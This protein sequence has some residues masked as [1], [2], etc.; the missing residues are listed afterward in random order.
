MGSDITMNSAHPTWQ[1][2]TA[3][4]GL[5]ALVG[6]AVLAW[7]E[8]SFRQT[9]DVIEFDVRVV[10]DKGEPILGLGA[11]K[12]NVTI[13]GSPRHVAS[14]ALAHYGIATPASA[15][16]ATAP[17][18]PIWSA[19]TPLS[20]A[21]SSG[22]IFVLVIDA[23]TFDG[24]SAGGVVQAARD[25]VGHLQLND[26]VGLFVFPTGSQISP[27]T[28]RGRVMN[29]LE[30]VTG[31][32]SVTPGVEFHLRPSE[33]VALAPL[34]NDRTDRDSLRLVDALCGND[35][36]C[37]TRLATEVRGLIGHYEVH[38]LQ[39]LSLLR[40]L[41]R[42]LAVI[43]GRKTLVL[44]SGGVV[45]SNR[46]GGRPDIGNLDLLIGEEAIRTNTS[47]YTLYVDWNYSQQ[48]T[49]ERRKAARLV[50]SIQEDSVVL[51]R[52][53]EMFTGA[54]GGALFKALSGHGE[55]AFNRILSET[56]AYYVLGVEPAEVDR[57]GKPKQLSVKV[58]QSG[59]T[60]RGSRWV[61][62]PKR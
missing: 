48:F 23:S 55:V 53:L 24:A 44:L 3:I 21:Q 22:R 14:A 54:S 27:T 5:V 35:Q 45:T 43:Q 52:A 18:P 31:N 61:T 12:F 49:A 6:G 39:S 25:F 51:S 57:D 8:P 59:A 19:P 36:L 60:V 32:P 41:I 9:V 47:I 37:A 4:A 33:L 34:A 15:A 42:N 62:V 7:Q 13:N 50:T 58:K 56:S 16:V 20:M 1:R 46:P 38:A 11:D 28:D 30:R 40:T 29:A 10:T 2:A 26:M 17:P